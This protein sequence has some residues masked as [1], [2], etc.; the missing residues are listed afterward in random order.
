ME[1]DPD[2]TAALMV[3]LPEA[4][5]L[6]VTEDSSGLHI[7]IETA[8]EEAICRQC[9]ETAV[10]GG[11]RVMERVGL[12]IFGRPSMFAWRVREW[13]CEHPGCPAGSWLDEIPD[14]AKRSSLSEG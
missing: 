7:E 4:R 9:G 13:A 5:V 2:R 14:S 12:S 8:E 6:E 11:T 10:R 3:G 1:T